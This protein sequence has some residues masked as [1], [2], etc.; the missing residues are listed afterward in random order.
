MFFLVILIGIFL[1]LSPAFNP[2]LYSLKYYGLVQRFLVFTMFIYI[3]YLG[4]KIQ[5]DI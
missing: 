3:A 5:M 1:N 4:K 2:E